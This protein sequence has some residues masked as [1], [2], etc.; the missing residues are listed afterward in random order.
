MNREITS[1]R[2]ITEGTKSKAQNRKPRSKVK[3]SQKW[4][5]KF[6]NDSGETAQIPRNT[7]VKFKWLIL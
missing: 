4:K 2:K 1:G 3:S 6:N 5:R 7:L